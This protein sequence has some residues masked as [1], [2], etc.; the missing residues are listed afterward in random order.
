MWNNLLSHWQQDMRYEQLKRQ[1]KTSLCWELIYHDVSR[2]LAHLHLTNKLTHLLT[3]I[4]QTDSNLWQVCQWLKKCY[5][6]T[7]YHVQQSC[8]RVNKISTMS[9]HWLCFFL[10]VAELVKLVLIIGRQLLV[11]VAIQLLLFVILAL[12]VRQNIMKPSHHR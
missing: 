4:Q 12:L 9:P 2:L 1:L 11:V 8:L 7:V 5:L 3:Y 10:N 6:C